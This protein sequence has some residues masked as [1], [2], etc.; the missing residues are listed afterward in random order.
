[1][2][3]GR[4]VYLMGA[5]GSGKDSVLNH[6][7]A[8]L[9]GRYDV[10][11]AHRYVTRPTQLGHENYVSLSAGEHDLRRD[12]GL[13]LMDWSAH[14]IRYAVG[15]EVSIWLSHG[16][17][18][19]MNGSRAH[20]PAAAACQP[21][22]LP[23]LIDVPFACLRQRLLARGRE[24]AAEIDARLERAGALTV[25]HPALVRIDNTGPLELAGDRLSEILMAEAARC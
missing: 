11:I 17:V 5:S 12:R 24:S 25:T 7:R 14:G 19:V 18:V 6:A 8:R 21:G 10:L 9:D 2:S 4:L 23:I 3:S 13:F 15:I 20:L 1:M 22:M 16:M